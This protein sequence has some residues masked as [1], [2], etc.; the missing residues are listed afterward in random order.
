MIDFYPGATQMLVDRSRVFIGALLNMPSSQI[1]IV[2][3]KTAC[4]AP[5][6]AQDVANFFASDP[7][8]ASTHFI[9]GQDGTVV[10][11]VSL[12]DGAGGNCCVESGYDSYWTPLLMRFGN[13]NL[14]TISIEHCDP[15]SD[16][17][18]Q[19]TQPQVDASFKLV[20]WLCSTFNIPSTQIKTHQ[21]IDPISR[22]HC[23]GNYPFGHLISSIGGSTKFMQQ[24]FD[25]IWFNPA[26][27]VVS[28]YRSG[29][30]QAVLQA[31]LNKSCSACYPT[32]QEI[33]TVDWS[34][35]SIKF[36]TLS[37]GFHAE[38]NADNT[39][40]VYSPSGARVL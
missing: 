33:N 32:S 35:N 40:S 34:G 37:N 3:H 12:V 26:G 6:T 11:C 27:G 13:L 36:Q 2:I 5:C 38:W 4:G 28:G 22:A 21:S 10:Q 20:Q 18:T 14:C 29:I 39:G 16:N 15:S 25:N 8:E 17:S 31:F 23:P 24:Q 7:A 1:T 19:C 30:Y 9:I